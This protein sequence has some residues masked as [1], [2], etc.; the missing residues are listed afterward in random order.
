MQGLL[1]WRQC[2]AKLLLAHESFSRTICIVTNP[3]ST[4]CD[5]KKSQ[6]QPINSSFR[7]HLDRCNRK[8]SG[9]ASLQPRTL[10]SP[11]V[12]LPPLL[13]HAV[14]EASICRTDMHSQHATIQA[15]MR[16]V[17]GSAMEAETEPAPAAG[18]GPGSSP[19]LCAS[20]AAKAADA[21]SCVSTLDEAASGSAA[22]LEGP[23]QQHCRCCHTAEAF[24]G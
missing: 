22:L 2:A 12:W 1:L 23:V 15:A 16:R 9:P 13:D 20:A 11:C 18:S 19:S 24:V 10:P 8:C 5:M 14:I 7:I 21:A 17:H 4:R 3:A 6:S